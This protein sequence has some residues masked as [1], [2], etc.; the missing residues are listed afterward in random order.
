[1]AV[2][3]TSNLPKRTSADSSDEVRNFFDKY[4]LHQI[5]FPTNQIDAI[6]GFFLSEIFIKKC[7]K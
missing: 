5:T 3:Q 6:V 2:E 1:M 7:Q 4:F